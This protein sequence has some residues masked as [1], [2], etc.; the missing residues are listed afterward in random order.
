MHKTY[1]S[2][3]KVRNSS[4]N[5]LQ[6]YK[7]WRKILNFTST[8]FRLMYWTTKILALAKRSRYFSPWILEICC[9]LLNVISLS[10]EKYLH[11]L[12][13]QNLKIVLKF[14]PGVTR[15]SLRFQE[16]YFQE[17]RKRA[18]SLFKLAK[19]IHSAVLANEAPRELARHTCT[20][21]LNIAYTLSTYAC[22]LIATY[23]FIIIRIA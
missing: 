20:N 3:N 7:T 6:K 18:F 1:E 12:K 8:F 16:S 14:Y 23:G 22:S 9:F 10:S 11:Y 13:N 21:L 15:L 4:K 19:P 2:W 17:I 5:L